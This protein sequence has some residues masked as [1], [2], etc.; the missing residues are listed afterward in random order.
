MRVIILLLV[1]SLF[2]PAFAEEDINYKSLDQEGFGNVSDILK[3]M[4]EGQRA[5]VLRQAK[6]LEKELQTYSP[7]E[8]EALKNS[9][10]AIS[11]NIPSHNVDAKSLD[12]KK[13]KGLKGT[14]ED[15]QLYHH[16]Y[17]K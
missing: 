17:G 15:M 7:E 6:E 14:Q 9:L 13:F 1:L 4:D 12:P 2:N 5:E 11:N 16:R 8:Q 3:Q 10:Q